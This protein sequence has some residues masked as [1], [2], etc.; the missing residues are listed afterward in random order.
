M[1]CVLAKWF[2]R[3]LSGTQ[4]SAAGRKLSLVPLQVERLGD[5]LVPALTF[6][7]P[8]TLWKLPTPI[9]SIVYRGPDL[10]GK[11]VGITNPSDPNNSDVGD[12]SF[13]KLVS[14]GKG[15]ANFQGTFDSELHSEIKLAFG[16]ETY[17]TNLD[18]GP[19]AITGHL[20]GGQYT[21]GGPYS[22]SISFQG[23]AV[24]RATE[25]HQ[26]YLDDP[27]QP[28][29]QGTQEE[30][31]WGVL[32]HQT[33]SFN[34]T[35]SQSGATLMLKGSVDVNDQG[36][37]LGATDH[38]A[39]YNPNHQIVPLAEIETFGQTLDQETHCS[40]SDAIR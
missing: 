14:D 28:L 24:G 32:D 30:E 35:V 17:T 16:A 37:W 34:G 19:I 12:V 23:D 26:Y 27:S 20:G 15:G 10:T 29:Q 39:S 31:R 21:L 13:T 40:V 9:L 8:L 11:Q 1:L 38:L 7:A 33:I 4:V 3:L 6:A 36:M 2:E 25:D 5:R 18:V 22:Y